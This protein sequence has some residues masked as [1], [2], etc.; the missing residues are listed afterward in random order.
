MRELLVRAAIH[1]ARLSQP[2]ALQALRPLA[3]SI[4][5]PALQAAIACL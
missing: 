2:T 3:E 4:D 5:N 1:R